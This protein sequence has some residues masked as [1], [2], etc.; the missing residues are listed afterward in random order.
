[1]SISPKAATAAAAARIVTPSRRSVRAGQVEAAAEE[2]RGDR[3]QV[4][5]DAEE[6]APVRGA[7]AEPVLRRIARQTTTNAP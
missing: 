1:M 7:A 5:A 3:Q 2:V 4:V 6:D